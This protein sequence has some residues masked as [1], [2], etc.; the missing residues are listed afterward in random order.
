MDINDGNHILHTKVL[1]D[2]VATELGEMWDRR[3]KN[4]DSEWATVPE[5]RSRFLFFPAKRQPYK[6]VTRVSEQESKI[7]FTRWLEYNKFRFSVET[8]TRK[9]YKQKPSATKWTSGR[10][11]VTVYGVGGALDRVLNIELKEGTQGGIRGRESFRKDLEQLLREGITGLWFHTLT[12]KPT[13]WDAIDTTIYEALAELNGKTYPID[14]TAPNDP[15]D[16][17]YPTSDDQ[18]TNAI[19]EASHTI[20]FVFCVLETGTIER[21]FIIDFADSSDFRVLCSFRRS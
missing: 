16:P 5:E 3:W 6:N 7:L 17:A 10:T 13:S 20:E 11:D 8:P 19:E 2:E 1:C 14:P 12:K 4:G 18:L 15:V 21:R 9:V